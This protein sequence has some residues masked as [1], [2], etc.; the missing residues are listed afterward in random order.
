MANEVALA[1]NLAHSAHTINTIIDRVEKLT[2]FH[3]TS[4][5][6]SST[7][8]H[9]QQQWPSLSHK[10]ISPLRRTRR[11]CP[12]RRT[13]THQGDQTNS[14]ARPQGGRSAR[15]LVRCVAYGQEDTN[16]DR[17]TIEWTNTPDGAAKQFRREWFQGDG[18]V[19]RKNLPI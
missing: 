6:E 2:L 18:M 9:H 1:F 8:F 17:I 14:S 11:S 19:R 4:N 3:R 10:E 5:T 15:R 16:N 7:L 12:T 13:T